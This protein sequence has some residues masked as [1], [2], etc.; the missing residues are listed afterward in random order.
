[1]LNNQKEGRDEG[2]GEEP[3]KTY[4]FTKVFNI[5]VIALIFGIRRQGVE[6]SYPA[7]VSRRDSPPTRG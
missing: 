4:N 2:G 3:K 1:M 5:D 6:E 7:S